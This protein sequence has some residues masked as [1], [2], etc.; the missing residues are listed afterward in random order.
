MAPLAVPSLP[1][2]M[3]HLCPQAAKLTGINLIIH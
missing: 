3:C 1:S 2:L